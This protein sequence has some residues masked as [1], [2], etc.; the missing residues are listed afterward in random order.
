MKPKLRGAI[1]EGIHLYDVEKIKKVCFHEAGHYV[2]AKKL[3]FTTHGINIE[4]HGP[5]DHS[6]EAIIEP[7]TVGLINIK[8]VEGYLERRIKVLYAGV[9]AQSFTNEEGYN[10]EYAT[11]EWEQGSGV[12]DHAKIRELTHVLRNV[13]FPKTSD[14]NEAQAELDGVVEQLMDDAGHIVY[15]Y[16]E[17]I[18]CIGDALYD[19]VKN[20]RMKYELTEVELNAMQCIKSLL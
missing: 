7:L 13:R 19:K 18:R 1:G 8:S 2:V 6:G 3:G 12:N 5:G 11:A 15:N 14:E 9:V 20:Y 16:L 17:V 4:C 10:G